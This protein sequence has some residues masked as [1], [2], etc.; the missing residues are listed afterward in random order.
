MSKRD[1]TIPIQAGERCDLCNSSE[2]TPH[3]ACETLR[4]R[5]RSPL[6]IEP[7]SHRKRAL[8]GFGAMV[9]AYTISRSALRTADG[10]KV[11][12]I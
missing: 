1:W 10:M 5:I 12:R 2:P 7:E 9:D 11:T 3:K 8:S 6:G 4:A